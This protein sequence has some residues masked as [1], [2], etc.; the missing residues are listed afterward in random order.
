MARRSSL[1]GRRRQGI[2]TAKPNVSTRPHFL[3]LGYSSRFGQ[4]LRLVSNATAALPHLLL[5]VFH[6]RSSLP[7]LFYRITC[8]CVAPFS[9]EAPPTNDHARGRVTCSRFL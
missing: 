6:R 2:T 5:R 9:C 3:P 1:L 8:D 4:C 7:S